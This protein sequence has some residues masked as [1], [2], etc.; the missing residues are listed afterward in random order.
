MAPIRLE[1]IRPADVLMYG[2]NGFVNRA[3]QIKTWSRFSHV[4]IYDGA[5]FA[6]A[7][8]NGLGVGRYEVRRDGLLAVLRLR[9][10]AAGPGVVPFDIGAARAW[11]LS[12]E[13]Q[14]YDWIGLLSFTVAEWQGR[15]NAAQFCSEF[16]ARYFRHGIGAAVGIAHGDR[17]ALKARGLDPWRGQP[18]DALAPSAFDHSSFFEEGA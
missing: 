3:I 5:G 2:G 18:A 10:G 17:L 4:E 9:T 6:W 11:A 7:S 12:V 14:A 8:R 13:G 1:D 15:E 16:G